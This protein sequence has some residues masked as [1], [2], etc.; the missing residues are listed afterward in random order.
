MIRI[1]IICLSNKFMER[2]RSIFFINSDS[3][4]QSIN[5][6]SIGIGSNQA[7]NFVDVS[8]NRNFTGWSIIAFLSENSK[9]SNVWI[10]IGSFSNQVMEGFFSSFRIYSDSAHQSIIWTSIGSGSNLSINNRRISS[11]IRFKRIQSM[12]HWILNWCTPDTA[13]NFI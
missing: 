11:D 3:A 7:I 4:H 13:K 6:S 2:F 9:Q 1:I 8:E 12:N 10:S 5:C